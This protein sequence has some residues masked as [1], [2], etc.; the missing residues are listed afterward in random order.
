MRP[1]QLVPILLVLFIYSLADN[2]DNEQDNVDEASKN[3]CK[4]TFL[5][6]H[7]IFL[8]VKYKLLMC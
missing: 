3:Y 2:T 1:I 5:N 4:Y 6:F 7:L 8:N